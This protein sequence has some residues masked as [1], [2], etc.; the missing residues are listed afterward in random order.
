LGIEGNSNVEQST[1][2]AN[3]TT[4]SSLEQGRTTMAIT[5]DNW[6]IQGGSSDD[7]K[8]S[9]NVHHAIFSRPCFTSSYPLTIQ[10][11]TKAQ[12]STSYLSRGSK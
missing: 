7:D 5:G 2:L 6:V 10:T 4:Y 12:R 11:D 3:V 8:N 9:F 1:F